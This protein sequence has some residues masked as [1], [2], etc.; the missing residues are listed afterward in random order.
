MAPLQIEF[1]VDWLRIGILEELTPQ[2]THLFAH[3]LL[4]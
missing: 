2:E 4:A 3:G 1:A